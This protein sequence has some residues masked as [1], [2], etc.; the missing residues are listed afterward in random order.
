MSVIFNRLSAMDGVGTKRM[1]SYKKTVA[2]DNRTGK[3][4]YE[5]F[6]N[7]F[8]DEETTGTAAGSSRKQE[9]MILQKFMKRIKTS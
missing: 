2:G 9:R 7:M 4:I 3:Q 6:L 1:F 5:C 8:K